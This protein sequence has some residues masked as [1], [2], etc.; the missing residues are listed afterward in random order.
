MTSR[1]LE[2]PLLFPGER[3]QRQDGSMPRRIRPVIDGT[4]GEVRHDGR[5]WYGVVGSWKALYRSTRECPTF[6]IDLRRAV[7]NRRVV[8]PR[9][10]IEELRPR[11]L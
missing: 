4:A 7:E 11:G 1:H 5:I 2:L 8:F 9:R 6:D 3:V 10:D